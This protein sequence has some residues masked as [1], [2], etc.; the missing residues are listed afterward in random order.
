MLQNNMLRSGDRVDLD[1]VPQRGTTVFLN[2]RPVGGRFPEKRFNDA[3]L[4]V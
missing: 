2:G 4:A 3:L 1:Y